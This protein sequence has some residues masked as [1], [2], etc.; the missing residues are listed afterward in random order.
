MLVGLA[1]WATILSTASIVLRCP[2]TDL[3][4]HR[5]LRGPSDHPGMRMQSSIYNEKRISI[6][7]GS[8]VMRDPI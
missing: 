6:Y 7:A 3:D 8:L 2:T 1:C 5:Q 4:K